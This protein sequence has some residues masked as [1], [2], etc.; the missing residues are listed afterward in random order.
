MRIDNI[1]DFA[2]YILGQTKTT[3]LLMIFS[4]VQGNLSNSLSIM[5]EYS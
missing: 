2:S 3:Y 5:E 4:F 1:N